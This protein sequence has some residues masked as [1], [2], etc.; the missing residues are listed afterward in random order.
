MI[1]Q[2]L[3]SARITQNVP[4]KRIAEDLQ[5]DPSYLSH[6]E[7]GR[8][9][10]TSDIIAAYERNLSL[11]TPLSESERLF[12]STVTRLIHWFRSFTPHSYKKLLNKSKLPKLPETD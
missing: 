8:R 2:T 10:V 9:T 12:D 6:V 1:G 5:V 11:S 4:L 3:R 7:H